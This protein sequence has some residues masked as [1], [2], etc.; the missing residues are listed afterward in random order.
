MNFVHSSL[1][2]KFSIAYYFERRKRQ[3]LQA[4]RA[5]IHLGNLRNNIQA[6]RKK[7]GSHPKI[8]MPVKAGAYGHGAVAVSR[9]A[10]ENGVEY[11]GVAG[12]PEGKELRDAGITAP[13]L[14]FSQVLPEELPAI[15]S[16]GL[17]P[18]VSDEEFIREAAQ[19]AEQAGRKLNL[20]LKVDTGMGRMG[21]KPEEA[22]FLAKKIVS[23]KHLHLE[24][25]ATHLS[26]SDSLKNCDIAYTKEQLRRFK[27]VISSIEDAGLPPG[28]VHAAN[29]GALVFHEDSYFDM[30][31]PGIFLYGYS[32]FNDDP[33]VVPVMEL[34]SKVVF[35]K[36]VKKG[37]SV[38][39]GRTWI[40]D[41]DTV[42]GV[43]P[44][45]YADGFRRSLSND[46]SF[47]IRGRAYPLAGTIC[48]DQ[49]M[50]NLGLETDVQRW[51]DAVVFGPGFINASDIAKKLNTISYEITCGIN[52]RVL[53][54]YEE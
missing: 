30:I 22:A 18:F 4:N 20:H 44:I 10:L 24:G 26:V 21:C 54:V 39:Y 40:A 2:P 31:R 47:L 46:H 49:C 51:D 42:I 5:I 34:R 13:I 43:V 45:G 3:T 16:L 32:P 17:S 1:A 28:I 23:S 7:A 37:E 48:M 35:F 14:I 6:A 50:V 53:R 33:S 29:S 9:C 11:L 36:R 25:T 15:V 8:C 38:S 12:F 52:K 19:E 27:E 41:E